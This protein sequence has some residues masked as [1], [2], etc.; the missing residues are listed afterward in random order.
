MSY[1]K[2]THILPTDLLEKV[3]EYVNGKCIYIPR[4][5]DNKQE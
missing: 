5:A 3:Q 4:V 2:A 1:L